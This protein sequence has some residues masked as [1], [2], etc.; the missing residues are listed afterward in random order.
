MYTEDDYKNKCNQLGLIYIGNHK[1]KK[2]GTIIDF[3]CPTHDS[4][5]VQ[6]KDWSHFKDYSKGCPYCSGRYRTT[7]EFQ[8]MILNKSLVVKSEYVGSEKPIKIHCNCCN[9]DFICNRPIDLIK[10]P[11]GCPECAKKNAGLKRRSTQESFEKKMQ[12][13]NPN[14][15]VI[16]KYE[17]IHKLI[18][19]K[20][21]KCGMEWES[22]GSNLY[23]GKAGCPICN[24]SS[25]ERELEEYLIANNINYKRQMTFDDCRDILPLRFDAYD[26][27]NIIAFEFQGE[28]HYFPIDFSGDGEEAAKASLEALQRRDKIKKDY[29][30]NKNIRLVCI[31][32]WERGNVGEFLDSLNLYNCVA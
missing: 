13:V 7:E 14:I 4:V 5:G 25:G 19:C 24:C 31:P 9:N 10:R 8:K 30:Y 11:Y 26:I 28:Q 16:G 2:R 6:G 22:Y 15:S 21:N 23:Q 1:E 32:Y 20:C 29:C 3:I 12:E 27:D 18:R 17:G